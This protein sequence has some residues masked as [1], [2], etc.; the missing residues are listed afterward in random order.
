[1]E[2]KILRA[3]A[4]PGRLQIVEILREDPL[5]VGD[6]VDRLHIR[7]PQVSKNLRVPHEAGV[8]E[9][10]AD[11][12]RRIYK[13]RPEAFKELNLWLGQYSELWEESFEN[14]DGYLQ[15]LQKG[16]NQKNDN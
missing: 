16:R 14:L 8:V 12:N 6:I 7:Q 9:Y 10:K 13:L 1:M 11:A 2:S 3:L 4:E 15:D 5:T